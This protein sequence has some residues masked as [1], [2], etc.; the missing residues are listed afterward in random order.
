[1]KNIWKIDQVH[2]ELRFEIDYLMIAKLSGY[3]TAFDAGF[4]TGEDGFKHMEQIRFSAQAGSINTNNGLRDQ[5]LL[6]KDFFDAARYPDITFVGTDFAQGAAEYPANFLAVYRKDFK[7]AGNL[8]IKGITRPVT[9]DGIYGGSALDMEGRKKAGFTVKAK[10]NRKDF[11][12]NAD[13]LTKA[14]KLALGEEITITS[15]CQFILEMQ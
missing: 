4:Q 5:H 11:G 2:S 3:L 15:N 1:M 7:I 12:L 9:L 13:T 10:I 14:G 6:S 8:M